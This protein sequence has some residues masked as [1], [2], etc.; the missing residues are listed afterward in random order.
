[1]G[2]SR[3]EWNRMA[4]HDMAWGLLWGRGCGQQGLKPEAQSG[5]T[6]VRNNGGRQRGDANG[7]AER[8]FSPGHVWKIEPKDL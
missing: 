4:W 6:R 7:G 2:W 5:V 3:M 1:M 8:R